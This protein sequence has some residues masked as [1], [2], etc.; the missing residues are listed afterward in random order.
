M[1]LCINSKICTNINF[2]SI[3]IFWRIIIY[4]YLL[5]WG[6]NWV[7]FVNIKVCKNPR[8][9]GNQFLPVLLFG[10]CRVFLGIIFQALTKTVLSIWW[11]VLQ[12]PSSS[13]PKRPHI[14]ITFERYSQESESR[15]VIPLQ[16]NRIEWIHI[17]RLVCKRHRQGSYD[18]T[19]SRYRP[20]YGLKPTRRDHLQL[21]R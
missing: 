20:S 2:I 4:F 18:W 10:V 13:T 6:D 12:C 3:C 11:S 16:I 15:S 7:S 14:A 17:G 5:V 19:S 1:Y 9:K 21:L 8:R